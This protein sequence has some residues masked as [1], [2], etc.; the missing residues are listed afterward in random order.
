MI[1]I[2]MP[3]RGLIFSKTVE[4]VTRG[5]E[6]LSGCG[7]GSQIVY[8]HDLPIPESF[9]YTVETNFQNPAH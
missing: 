3:S 7:I 9:N 2:C 8:S 4:S 6:A 1:G 5:R